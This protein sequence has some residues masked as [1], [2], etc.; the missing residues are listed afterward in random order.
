MRNSIS[1]LM[2]VVACLLLAFIAVNA[3]AWTVLMFREWQGRVVAPSDRNPWLARIGI[4]VLSETFE[5]TSEV[6]LNAYLN[7]VTTIRTEY[8]PYAGVRTKA[9]R[10]ERLNVFDPGFRGVGRGEEPWPPRKSDF[11]VFMFGGSTGFGAGVADGDTIAAHLAGL[12]TPL[13]KGR[14]VRIYNFATPTHFS[15]MERGLFLHLMAEGLRPDIAIFLDGLNDFYFWDGVPPHT[16]HLVASFDN[17]RDM[18]RSH[19]WTWHMAMAFKRA[20]LGKVLVRSQGGTLAGAMPTSNIR[21]ADAADQARIDLVVSRYVSNVRII[22]GAASG[23]GVQVLFVLQPVPFYAFSDLARL[24][25]EFGGVVGEHKRSLYGYPL[26]E[27]VG[28]EQLSGLGFF[29]CA[30]IQEGVTGRL[31]VDHVHYNP[32]MSRMVAECVAQHVLR[33]LVPQGRLGVTP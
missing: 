20:P 16:N 23:L 31:Y 29:S 17:L 32:R 26:L 9:I 1:L 11:V 14:P 19:D 25:R 27:R 30:R 6:E 21:E 7:E 13:G 5:I 3:M 33:H 2:V 22:A 15:S 10:G 12:L 28:M 4:D 18:G 24:M 8:Q